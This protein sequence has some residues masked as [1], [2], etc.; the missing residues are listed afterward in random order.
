MIQKQHKD[1]RYFIRTLSIVVGL[2][3]IWRGI[4]HILDVIEHMYFGGEMFWTS[5]VGIL[6]GILLLYIPDHDLKEIE[7]L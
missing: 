5:V 7:K 2:V 1:V 3:M 6:I 4:W